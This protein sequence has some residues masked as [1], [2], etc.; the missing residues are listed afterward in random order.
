MACA[1]PFMRWGC[2]ELVL[3]G[4]VPWLGHD[5]SLVV[6]V[7]PFSHMDAFAI[8]GFYALYGRS[9]S[10]KIIWI[11]FAT[12]LALGIVVSALFEAHTDWWGLGYSNFMQHSYKYVWGYTLFNL[13]FALMLANIRDRQRPGGLLDARWLVYLGSISY[14]L[15]IFHSGFIWLVE[16]CLPA[17]SLPT[18][19]LLSLVPTVALSALSYAYLEKPCLRLKDRFFP[20]S[21]R[22]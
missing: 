12:I 14:G 17:S 21:R 16:Y 10:A 4:A 5:P 2:E 19:L 15:Y 13:C 7:S 1:G 22:L 8:G 3:S 6:Y 20:V 18:K 11:F 9:C